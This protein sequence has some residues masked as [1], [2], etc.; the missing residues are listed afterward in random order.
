MLKRL[1]L[2]LSIYYMIS[3]VSLGQKPHMNSCPVLPWERGETYH[4]FPTLV[5]DYDKLRSQWWGN[6]RNIDYPPT[7]F[8]GFPKMEESPGH[9][10]FPYYFMVS[11]LDN[12]GVPPW[13]G[14]FHFWALTSPFPD[15]SDPGSLVFRSVPYHQ[16]RAGRGSSRNHIPLIIW[17]IAIELWEPNSF[18]RRSWNQWNQWNHIPLITVETMA[19]CVFRAMIH[20]GD[21]PWLA[22]LQGSR[23]ASVWF[24]LASRIFIRKCT[25]VFN[26]SF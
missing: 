16:V 15:P 2:S 25:P 7:T 19:W 4:C 10:G 24:V 8:L 21:F 3:A 18:S 22:G 13:P 11:W 12:L 6:V 23:Y 5:N 26:S 9:H 14:N 20:I 17:K 1:W